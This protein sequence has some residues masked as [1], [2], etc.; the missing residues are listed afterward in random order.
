[1]TI[2]GQHLKRFGKKGEKK[3]M[4]NCLSTALHSSAQTPTCISVLPAQKSFAKA[5]KYPRR[6]LY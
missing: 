6:D 2:S 4:S 5:G 1:M 3:E